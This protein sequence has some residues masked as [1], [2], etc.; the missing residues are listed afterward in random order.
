MLSPVPLSWTV[1]L[2]REPRKVIVPSAMNGEVIYHSLHQNS[3]HISVVVCISAAGEHMMPFLFPRRPT[4]R[5][6]DGFKLMGSDWE[7]A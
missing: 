6:N 4:A 2:S 1:Q 5:C 7:L 3:K